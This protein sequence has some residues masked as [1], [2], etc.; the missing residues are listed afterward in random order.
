[1]VASPGRGDGTPWAFWGGGVG[2]GAG[3]SCTAGPR[4][5]GGPYTGAW[6]LPGPCTVCPRASGAAGGLYALIPLEQLPLPLAYVS[7]SAKCN[8]GPKTSREFSSSAH[9]GMEV[10]PCHMTHDNLSH[11]ANGDPSP[12]TEELRRRRGE[13]DGRNGFAPSEL[14]RAWSP[15]NPPGPPSSGS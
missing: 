6:G 12:T 5:Q 3:P 9:E 13:S 15:S 14:S 7:R 1:M 4:P 11:D 8:L 10:V 2:H